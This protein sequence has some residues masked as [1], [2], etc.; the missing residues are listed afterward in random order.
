[1]GELTIRRN[2]GPS[3]TRYQS[4]GRA[5]KTSGSAPGQKTAR[6]TG[7]TVSETLRQL[8]TRM[9]QAEVRT[10]ESRRTLQTG[11]GVLAEVQDSLSRMEELAR[12]AG[13][14]TPDRAALQ[15]ELEALR[16][17]IDRMIG[18]AAAG[19][20]PLFL[21]G[22]PED[23]MEALLPAA[24]GEENGGAAQ[25][26][27]LPEWLT[28]ALT[29]DIP[30]PEALLAALGLDKTASGAELLAA[31]ANSPLEPG[32]AAG[33]LAA[34]YL[35][36]VIAGADPSGEIDPETALEGLRQLLERISEGVPPD[37]AI[38]ELTG[39]VFTGL[40]DFQSQFTGGT[41][42]GLEDFLVGL[43]LTEGGP[44]LPDSVL[45]LLTGLEG[46]SLEL[47]MDLLTASQ[48]AGAPEEQTTKDASVPPERGA[49]G[50]S[51]PVTV[52]RLGPAQV[53][54]R[55]PEALSFREGEG[56]LTVDGS[57][58]VT[59]RGTEE[60]I[61]VLRITGSGRVIL[62]NITA[63]ALV[64][65]ASSARVFTL[66]RSEVGEVRL[67]RDSS[68]TVEGTGLLKLGVLR[69]DRTN[70][71]RMTGGAV[72]LT[73]PDGRTLGALTVPVVLE[74]AASLAARADSVKSPAGEPLEPFDVVWKTLGWSAVSAAA[75][76]GRQTGLSPG[77]GH[78][79][80]FARLWLTR[81]DPS[82][83]NPIHTL[84]LRGRD[85]AGQLRSRYAYLRWN[86]TMR[87]FEELSMY[88]NPF[89]VVGGEAGQDWQYE[90][91]THTLRILSARVTA[92]SGG[93]GTDAGQKPYSGRVALADGIGR[94]ELSLEGVMCRVTRG[95][96]FS[97]GR[98]NQVTLLLPGGTSSCFESGAGCAG[99]SLGEGTSLRIDA[100]DPR[101]SRT[102]VGELTAAGRGGGAGIGRD[103]GAGRDR[104]GRILICGGA[105]T[106]AGSGGGAGI[107]AGKNG[108]MG[109][110]TITGGTVTST[111]GQGG[112]AGIGG[113]LNA[114]VGD[115]SIR[116][117]R[118]SAFAA[119]H[120]A[121]IGAGVQGECGDILITG[122]ARI[123]KALGGSPGADIGAC[124]FGGCGEV[125]ISGGAD[126]GSARL[127]TQAG[128]SLPAGEGAVTLPRFRL[129]SRALQLNSLSLSTRE[130]AWAA[131]RTVEAGRRWV[132]QLQRAY[133]A[134]HGQLDQR[135][136]LRDGDDARSL[137]D[138]MRQ[139]LLLQPEQAVQ[140]H[141]RR[142][143]EDV[144]QLLK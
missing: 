109:S 114:P 11:E 121:A 96:A 61:P 47:L 26:A 6:S 90:E 73:G 100:A 88:P 5:E 33:S 135:G 119:H 137:L 81:G 77:G 138:G 59:L 32:S 21:D 127:W 4:G 27:V 23:G 129:S 91:E 39:G 7:L 99:I 116:G 60:S 123:V 56:V 130:D 124:L 134:L 34:L 140:T 120:A 8:M 80:E 86:Q 102:P 50:G 87:A 94:L 12:Q 122:T 64:I 82:H 128:V 78:L 19:E 74:G 112:G 111:G 36:A 63:S 29:R 22:D 20:V 98:E 37:Q 132:S 65:D 83:G 108:F 71:L 15:A 144:Q 139:S 40:E 79:P 51:S 142:G 25:G 58:D 70:V 62:Q 107:G 113:G 69:G 136:S 141:G 49:E 24:L 115:I 105:V 89:T 117:G 52:L 133:S 42:P 17:E 72:V 53:L 57:R 48:S 38:E 10:R 75:V 118:I 103:C 43:L 125:L 30:A 13:G 110:I 16:G 84:F 92:I 106:A 45:A 44:V 41:A 93:S 131:R 35:G 85:E 104:T 1:M 18:S 97:L 31:I 55:E 14:E 54:S 28:A 68:L 46:R 126:I 66:G 143:K 101:D 3:V 2:R 9:S 76:D 67:E 95:R